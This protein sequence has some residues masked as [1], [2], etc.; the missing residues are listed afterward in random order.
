[1]ER[2]NS[3]LDSL[4]LHNA[5]VVPQDWG[6]LGLSWAAAHPERVSRLFILNSSIHNPEKFNVPTA[7]K[8]FRMPGVGEV[9]VK[10]FSMF[11]HAFLFKAGMVNRNRLTK[12]IRQ[13][14]LAPHAT[15]GSR[16]GVLE[17]PEKYP[18]VP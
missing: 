11:H 3:L 6:A 5:T 16:T 7:L 4:D 1:M 10:G 9:M 2:L 18:S 12:E 17:F 13:A 8:F 14:Y 15:W